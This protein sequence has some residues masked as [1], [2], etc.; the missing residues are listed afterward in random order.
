MRPIEWL[1][2]AISFGI[3]SVFSFDS[4]VLPKSTFFWLPTGVYIYS[5]FLAYYFRNFEASESTCWLISSSFAIIFLIGGQIL[6]LEHGIPTRWLD[7]GRFPTH[8]AADFLRNSHKVLTDGNFISIRG[9]P[10]ANAFLATVW[11]LSNYNLAV[12]GIV[13][14]C[15]CAGA[16][17]FFG[18][19]TVK[20]FGTTIGVLP[21]AIAIDFIHEHLGS[22]STEP[23]GFSMGLVSSGLILLTATKPSWV[24]FSLGIVSLGIAFLFRIGAIFVL[25]L[26]FIWGF[27][28]FENPRI[29]FRALSVAGLALIFV[30]AIHFSV[31][32]E[33]TPNSPSFVNGPKSWYAII[34]MGDDARGLRP[35][36]PIRES[37]RWLQIFD[38]HPG[39]S[40]LSINKQGRQ[41]LQII[42]ENAFERPMSVI[43]GIVVEYTDQLG[44]A[45]LFRFVDNKIIR[46]PLFLLFSFGLLLTAWRWRNHRMEALV[47]LCGVGM[48]SSIPFLHGGENRVHAPIIGII[49]ITTAL[50][51]SWLKDLLCQEKNS[52]ENCQNSF[53]VF[54]PMSF[55]TAIL[56]LSLCGAYFLPGSFQLTNVRCLDR[57][58]GIIWQSGSMVVV[59]KSSNDAY[60]LHFKDTRSMEEAISDWITIKHQNNLAFYAPIDLNLVR[61]AGKVIKN[62]NAPGILAM[63]VKTDDLSLE[64]RWIGQKHLTEKNDSC[65]NPV[66]H[67]KVNKN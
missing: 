48:L 23:I 66:K 5:A 49:G 7:W 54:L 59:S 65:F 20:I 13:I 42:A 15:I 45:G 61:N 63:V 28:I 47:L 34:A 57:S 55:I 41:F 17:A 51:L 3:I 19:M 36:R 50:T 39:L 58:T 31:S 12:M 40:D 4:A 22:L 52:F 46:L 26:I 30:V 6:I 56:I 33:L 1:I 64:R 24:T 35:N 29:R 11:H 16:L 27:F 44:R 18:A 10:M 2:V 32:R 53:T 8:D 9:R 43:V 37:A 67:P 14:S 38:D 62:G 21:I 60:S 25:P